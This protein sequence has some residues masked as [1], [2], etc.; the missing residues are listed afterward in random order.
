MPIGTALMQAGIGADRLD[1]VLFVGGPTYMPCIQKA[2]KE[3]LKRLGV[4][5]AVIAEIDN[6]GNQGFPVDPMECVARGASLKAGDIITEGQKTVSEGYGIELKNNYYNEIIEANSP[7]PLD[8]DPI[9]IVYDKGSLDKKISLIAKLPDPVDSNKVKYTDLGDFSITVAPTKGLPTIDVYLG[10]DSNKNVIAKLVQRRSGLE[11]NYEGLN[12]LKGKEIN[13]Q[14]DAAP[15]SVDP[16][17]QAGP[18]TSSISGEIKMTDKHIERYIRASTEVKG[19]VKNRT[20]KI[21]EKIKKLG[22]AVSANKADL[23]FYGA[24]VSNATKELLNILFSEKQISEDD[25]NR[26]MGEQESIGKTRYD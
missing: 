17:G 22:K 15:D 10:I 6:Y 25:Y 20:E 18:N 8:A 14:S 24:N 21:E 12:T 5:T 1:H 7:Y 26:Y 4:K 11:V 2:V 19:L 16:D 13:L 23:S 3:E 9:G